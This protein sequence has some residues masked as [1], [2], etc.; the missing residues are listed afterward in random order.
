M[1]FENYWGFSSG[2]QDDMRYTDNIHK[3]M[4]EQCEYLSQY[5]NGEVF[6]VFDEMKIAD[7]MLSKSQYKDNLEKLLVNMTRINENNVK[8]FTTNLIDINNV[9]SEEHYEF[10]ICTDEYRFRVFELIMTPVYPI[11]MIIDEGI[12]KN[13]GSILSKI[14]ETMEEPNYYE[15]RDEDIFCNVLKNIL[16]DRKVMFIIRELQK[17]VMLSKTEKEFLPEKV[18]ICEGERDEIIL[19]AIA[20]KLNCKVMVTS[21][22]GKDKVPMVFNAISDRNKKADFLIVVDS[23][24]NEEVVRKEIEEKISTDGYSLAIISNN[25]EELFFPEIEGFG[26]LKLMQSIDKII[27]EVDFSQISK[28]S[29]AFVKI[30][31]FLQK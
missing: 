19:Q 1:E 28:K 18:I 24:G 9:Y 29:D 26:K 25:I 11:K 7:V 31:D 16:H 2:L 10:Q 21:A 13:I 30:K 3:I 22:G 27:D 14:A 8:S 15:I 20:R 4:K 12:C 23:D 5:T 6:A 17:R